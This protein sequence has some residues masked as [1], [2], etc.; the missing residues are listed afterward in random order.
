MQLIDR[1]SYHKAFIDGVIIMCEVMCQSSVQN[2]SLD[3]KSPESLFVVPSIFGS[4]QVDTD[5]EVA[6]ATICF[7][8]TTYLKAMERVLESTC[9]TLTEDL[10]DGVAEMMNIIFGHAK[11]ELNAK[12]QTIKLAIPKIISDINNSALEDLKINTSTIPFQSDFGTF[13]LLIGEPIKKEITHV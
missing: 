5:F 4:I 3:N 12:G 13:H 2:G 9:D 1:E 11:K 8:Q 10:K 7:N 6:S